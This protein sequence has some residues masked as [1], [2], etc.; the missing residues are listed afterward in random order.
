MSM[1]TPEAVLEFWIGS[2]AHHAGDLDQAH[3][4]W[5]QKSDA[6]DK[7]IAD[8]FLDTLRL[9]AE[10]LAYEWAERGPRP[11]LAAVIVLDQ[12]SRNLFR[13]L[14]DAFAQDAIALG[15][16][17]EAIL[18]HEDTHLSE[19]ERAFLYLPLE[20]SERAA[21]QQLCVN[22]MEKLVRDA[23]PDFGKYAADSLDYAHRHKAIIDRFGRFPHRN[24][25]LGRPSTPE[26]IEFLK[27]P[28]SRF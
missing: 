18:K 20:H 22:L 19:T 4:F 6:T 27:Q 1:A 11:R 14:P 13:G 9:L 12:F 28:G 8:Q 15:L 16:S 3:R 7:A 24:A 21:D 23:R 26:E 5:F 2:T 10:G 25:V 17:K